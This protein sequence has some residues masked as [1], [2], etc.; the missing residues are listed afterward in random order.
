MCVQM[1]CPN[2]CTSWKSSW[3]AGSLVLMV[4]CF[5]Q[6]S[7]VCYVITS[8]LLCFWIG[9]TREG[10]R[11]IVVKLFYFVIVDRKISIILVHYRCNLMTRLVLVFFVECRIWWKVENI[12]SKKYEKVECNRG[13]RKIV[14]NVKSKKKNLKI[15]KT[16]LRLLDLYL[17]F[18]MSYPAENGHV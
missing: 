2:C 13:N 15:K 17:F 10:Q 11:R 6:L 8:D 4:M 7:A 9:L 3:A 14:D 12:L 5:I 18:S 1:I 16:W